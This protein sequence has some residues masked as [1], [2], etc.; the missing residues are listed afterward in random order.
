MRFRVTQ[1]AKSFKD[2]RLFQF[3]DI[4]KDIE[5]TE[6][7]QYRKPVL[8]FCGEYLFTII[9]GIHLSDTVFTAPHT[10]KSPG[11]ILFPCKFQGLFPVRSMH[12]DPDHFQ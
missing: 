12:D 7:K 8:E 3:N 2:N 4:P 9:A 11:S 5:L 10:A 6:R 1:D